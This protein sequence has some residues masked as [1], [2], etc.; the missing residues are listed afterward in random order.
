MSVLVISGAEGVGSPG[1]AGAPPTFAEVKAA[2]GAAD[3]ALDL[4]GQQV[5]NSATP[6]TPTALATKSYVD[7]A[8]ASGGGLTVATLFV[9]PISLGTGA[10]ALIAGG[11]SWGTSWTALKDTRIVNIRAYTAETSGTLRLKLWVGGVAVASGTVAITAAGIYTLATPFSYLVPARTTFTV[12]AY[13]DV[14]GSVGVAGIPYI[15]NNY[16]NTS[17]PIPGAPTLML[18]NPRLF[19][20]SGNPIEPW[21][22]SSNY[23]FAVEPTVGS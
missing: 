5:S 15:T 18:A 6:T 14:G 4:N 12:S 16:T 21:N 17:Y 13:P 19:D 22:T 20:G 3:S 23:I 8:V 1:G 10:W 11:Y 2:I 9:S 7:T